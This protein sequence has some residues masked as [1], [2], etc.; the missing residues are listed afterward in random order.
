MHSSVNN[1]DISTSILSLRELL[2]I[3]VVFSLVLYLLFPKD[4]IDKI[5]EYKGKNTNLSINYLETMLLYYPDNIKVKM[6]LM[7]N[8]QYASKNSKALSLVNQLLSVVKDRDMLDELYKTQFL[9]LKDLYFEDNNEYLLR[10]LKEKLRKYFEFSKDNIDYT[11]FYTQASQ[12]DFK[13]LKFISMKG[14]LKERPELINYAFEKDAFNQA[15]YLGFKDEAYEY[16]LHLLSYKEVEKEIQAYAISLL[17]EHENYLK[18]QRLATELF[19][20]AT[21]REEQI[22]YFNIALSAIINSK[23]ESSAKEVIALISLYQKNIELESSDIKFLIKALLQIGDLEGASS[24]AITAFNEHKDKFDQELVELAIKSLVWDKKLAKAL[25]ISLFAKDKFKSIKWLD[26]SIQLS[27]WQSKMQDVVKLNI[28]GYRNFK[29]FKY[30]KYLLT[31]STLNSAYKILGEIYTDKV[32]QGDYTFVKKLSEYYEYTGEVD[33]AEEYFTSLMKRVDNREI[34]REAIVFCY[35]NSHYKKGL[36]L[37]KDFQKKYGI[38]KKIQ[39]ISVEKLIALKRFKEAYAFAKELKE[40]RRLTDLG[41]LQK[42]Y[43][44]IQKNLWRAEKSGSL[45]YNNYDKLIRLDTALNNGDNLP[46][47]YKKLWKETKKR[48]YLVALFYLYLDKKDLKSIEQLLESLKPKDRAFF[49]NNIS[50]Q[51]AQANEFIENKDISSAL[52]IFST[53]LS[54]NIEDS[55]LHQS[56]LWF[57]LDNNLIEPMKSELAFLERNHNLQKEVGLPSVVVAIKLQKGD[58]ALHWLTPLLTTSDNIEYQVVYADLLELQDRGEG[59]NKVRLSLFRDL[60]HKIKENPNLLKDKEFARVYLGLVFRYQTPYAKR[61]T[62]LNSFKSLFS[63]SEL[64]DIKIGW[65]TYRGNS[66]M[67]RYLANKNKIDIPWL[68]F[69]LALSL[70]RNQKKQQLLNKYGSVLALK[71]KIVASLDIGDRAGAYSLTFKGMQSNRRDKELFTI[72][73]NM[74]SR[75]YPKSTLLLNYKHLTSNISEFEKIVTHRWNLYSGLEAKVSL[76]SYEY[77]QNNRGDSRDNLLSFSLK[78]SDKRFIWD[79]SLSRHFTD[80]SF[81]SASLNLNYNINGFELAL[82]S[83]Y[84]E[85]TTQTP[86]LQVDGMQSGVKLSLKKLLSQRIQVGMSYSMNDYKFQNSKSI[87]SSQHLQINSNYTL[88]AGYPDIKFS[89][90]LS[91]NSYKNSMIERFLPQNFMELGTQCTIGSSSKGTIHRSW[92]PFGTVGI[93]INSNNSIGTSLSLGI[94]STISGSDIL[95]LIF[96]YS[97]GID[98]ITSPYYGFHMDYQF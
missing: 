46:Y 7:K 12:L 14:F 52:K 53:V 28:E 41:W 60:N 15:L 9:L 21:K 18:M 96:D 82:K 64:M 48:N 76:K 61:A 85:K 3:I 34:E 94:S 90:Y 66:S 71:D 80:K 77:K 54:N 31:S 92:K 74:I 42:D 50:Y 62:Y 20:N 86:K 65:Y 19:L 25:K 37:Y 87:G 10:G 38:D 27:M 67:V 32:E 75:D 84:Q 8:Y 45:A 33:K 55:S 40:D 97:K 68:N 89:A 98:A 1:H 63:K 47:L 6:M 26:K 83:K 79:F 81:T 13:R 58:L 70:N 73:H 88:R 29:D 93:A 43:K 24:F 39:D 51:I 59:A 49:Q 56:Y 2:G 72:Y 4:D 30:E 23:R 5:I 91:S 22:K 44:F 69:Y 17:Y 36:N 35:E 95:N 11:F 78:N 57:L 16:L